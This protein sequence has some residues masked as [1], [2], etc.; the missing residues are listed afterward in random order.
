MDK[1][2]PAYESPELWDIGELEDLTLGKSGSDAD[3]YCT[4]EPPVFS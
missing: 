3:G 1:T 4:Q 2:T